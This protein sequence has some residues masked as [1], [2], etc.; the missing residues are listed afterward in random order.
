VNIDR[1]VIAEVISIP[2][3]HIDFMFSWLQAQV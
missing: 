3:L 1:E 2:F